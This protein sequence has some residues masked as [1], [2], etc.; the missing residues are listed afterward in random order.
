M[1]EDG[2]KY[3]SEQLAVWTFCLREEM[4]R[5]GW[6]TCH[7]LVNIRDQYGLC[8]GTVLDCLADGATG[9]IPDSP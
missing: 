2:G 7:L 9:M 4:T 1:I 5:C 8:N 6:K 3:Y